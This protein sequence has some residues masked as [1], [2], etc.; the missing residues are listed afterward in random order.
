MW[1]FKSLIREKWREKWKDKKYIVIREFG[2]LF[3]IHRVTVPLCHLKEFSSIRCRA[4][5]E[6]IEENC[7]LLYSDS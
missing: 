7:W 1:S 6:E 4:T 3:I 5:F 2:T